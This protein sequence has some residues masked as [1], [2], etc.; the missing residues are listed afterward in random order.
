[1]PSRPDDD[2]HRQATN[3]CEKRIATLKQALATAQLAISNATSGDKSEMQQERAAKKLAVDDLFA[4]KKALSDKRSALLDQ[5]KRIQGDMKKKGDALKNSKDKLPFKTLKELDDHVKALESQLG[6]GRITQLSEEKRIVAEISSL[7]KHRKTLDGLGSQQSS[8]SADRV[9]LDTLRA[10]LTELDPLRTQLNKDLDAAKAELNAFESARK[11]AVGG[12]T[13]LFTKRNKVKEELDAEFDKV[14]GLRAEYKAAKDAWFVHQRAEWERKNLEFQAKKKEERM[15]RLASDAEAEREAAEIPAFTD[16]INLCSNLVKHFDQ[17][18][19]SAAGGKAL[20]TAASSGEKEQP[21]MEGLVAL[22]KKDAREE[23]FMFM[24]KG[25]KKNKKKGGAA[26]PSAAS[27]SLKLD[28]EVMDQLL[29]LK[30]DEI[31]TTHADIPAV[32]KSLEARKAEFLAKQ[33]KA[34]EE[35]KRAA[36]AKI[37]KIK[38]QVEAEEKEAEAEEE[39]VEEE[40]PATEDA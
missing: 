22:K 34:T 3:E 38:A 15:A 14:K 19:K 25:G 35:N 20:D 39:A 37:A 13:D 26:A 10:Q 8:V 31:P 29:T 21:K 30:V 18:A 9:G 28:F 11:E 16:E 24:G 2:A 40:E 5:I 23:D 33:D 17:L 32:I 7:K 1:M 4:K 36:E 12:M 27:R 6:S